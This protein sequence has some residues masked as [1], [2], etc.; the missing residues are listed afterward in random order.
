MCECL[1][2]WFQGRGGEETGPRFA[3]QQHGGPTRADEDPSARGAVG[4]TPLDLLEVTRPRHRRR[5][6]RRRRRL[7]GVQL[8]QHGRRLTRDGG[9]TSSDTQQKIHDVRHKVGNTTSDA[10]RMTSGTWRRRMAWRMCDAYSRHLERHTRWH[11]W[12]HTCQARAKHGYTRV[13]P[14]LSMATHVSGQG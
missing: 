5:H 4:A 3:S 2:R 12:L 9:R 1:S 14:G 7:A 8:L 6:R 13:R 11:A 10:R